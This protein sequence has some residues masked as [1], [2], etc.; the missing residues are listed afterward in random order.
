MTLSTNARPTLFFI[1]SPIESDGGDDDDDD[2]PED[3][4]PDLVVGVDEVMKN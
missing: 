2:V 3:L 1:P 4:S